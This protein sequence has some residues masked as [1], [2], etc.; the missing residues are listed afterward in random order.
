[1][2]GWK[3]VAGVAAKCIVVVW[4]LCRPACNCARGA[5]VE[6]ECKVEAT[7]KTKLWNVAVS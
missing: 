4:N 2:S 5:E 6:V 3:V 1:M 7:E